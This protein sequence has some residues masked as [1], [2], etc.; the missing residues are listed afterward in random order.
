MSSGESERL[1][2]IITVA[3]QFNHPGDPM[4]IVI[5]RN[6]IPVAAFQGAP[7]SAEL[8]EFLTRVP[9]RDAPDGEP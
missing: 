8:T 9:W 5:G 1:K 4:S 2:A 6:G 7:T 3:G